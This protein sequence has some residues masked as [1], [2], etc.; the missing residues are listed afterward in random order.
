MIYH[1]MI[2]YIQCSLDVKA[3]Q[4]ATNYFYF[5]LF[6]HSKLAVILVQRD[7]LLNCTALATHASLSMSSS[8]SN[9]LPP[10]T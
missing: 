10:L 5:R 1:G 3:T 4:N 8:A 6:C 7:Y 2:V 9:K